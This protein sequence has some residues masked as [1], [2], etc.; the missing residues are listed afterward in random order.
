M[1]L[2]V[3]IDTM[4]S[5]TAMLADVILPECSYLERKDPLKSF[6]GIKPAIGLRLKVIEPMYDTKPI[7]EIMRGFSKKLTKPLW[8]VTKKHDEDALEAL[9]EE[10]EAKYYKENGF[11]LTEPYLHSQ[12]ELNKHAFVDKYGEGAWR[13]SSGKKASIT[14]K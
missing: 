14:Q 12:E 1:E 3:V 4:P 7:I 9:Q 6:P 10:E 2:V 13:V 11:H 8:E 5:D